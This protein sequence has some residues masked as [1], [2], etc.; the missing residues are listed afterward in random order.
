M[1][2]ALDELL[3]VSPIRTHL[4]ISLKFWSGELGRANLMFLFWFQNSNKMNGLTLKEKH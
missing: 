4:Q 2:F 3:K 1:I